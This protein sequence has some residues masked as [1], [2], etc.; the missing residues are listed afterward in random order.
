[1]VR[2]AAALLAIVLCAWFGLGLVQAK[3]TD[4]ATAILTAGTRLTAAEQRRVN[5]LL[6]TA[7]ALNPD[8]QV[9]VL[10]AQLR[11]DQGN[12]A[13]A[14]AILERVVQREPDNAVAWLWL[15]K[16]AAGS[17]RTFFRA[18]EHVRR[19]VPPVPPPS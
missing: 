15:A 6:N 17:P 8:S 11:L 7:G 4:R 14:R 12:P 18:L 13:A 2:I 3:N 19:L 5:D 9:D 16:S 10:R 1:M